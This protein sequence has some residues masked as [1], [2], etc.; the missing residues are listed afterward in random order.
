VPKP[1][2]QRREQVVSPK[3]WAAIRD[4][5]EDGDPFRDIL[6]FAWETGSR[7]QEAKRIEA[8]HVELH[9]HRVVI[10][11]AEAK[12]K[13]RWRVIY[14]T[15][16]AEHIIQR[17]LAVPPLGALFRNENGRPWT[18]QAMACR[19]ARL[20][21]RLGVKYA[22]YSIRHGFCQRLLEDGQ[23]HLTVAALMGHSSGRMVADVYSHMTRADDHLREA[24]KRASGDA[25]A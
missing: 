7:P 13:K 22:A 25:E 1:T 4:R 12:G 17:R 9:R 5:Y 6:E 23:D 10:P 2:P 24:L 18:S 8:R 20:K 15:D 19:F 3:E 16:R 21:K 14:L 11:P